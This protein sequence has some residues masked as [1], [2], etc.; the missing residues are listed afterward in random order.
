M[1]IMLLL[2][3]WRYVDVGPRPLDVC[4]LTFFGLTT[5]SFNFGNR[6]AWS[7]YY[8][9]SLSICFVIYSPPSILT[10]PKVLLR[11]RFSIFSLIQLPRLAAVTQGCSYWRRLYILNFVL[12]WTFLFFIS[13]NHDPHVNFVYFLLALSKSRAVVHKAVDWFEFVIALCRFFSDWRL[14]TGLCHDFHL[15]FVYVC[16]FSS[17]LYSILPRLSSRSFRYR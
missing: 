13:G 11:I 7:L 16:H 1:L 12:L 6:G 5:G 14:S 4:D 9:L 10:A 2:L 8:P 15:L 3:L 17:V